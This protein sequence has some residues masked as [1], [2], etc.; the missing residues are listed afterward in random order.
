MDRGAITAGEALK[1]FRR[2]RISCVSFGHWLVDRVDEDV[3]REA[4]YDEVA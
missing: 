2:H 1:T 3:T 4:V